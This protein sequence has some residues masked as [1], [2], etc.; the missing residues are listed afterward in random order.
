MY[1]MSVIGNDSIGTSA[2]KIRLNLIFGLKQRPAP[3]P[4]LESETFIEPRFSYSRCY[5]LIVHTLTA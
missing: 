1:N 2:E 5:L 3:V 4:D